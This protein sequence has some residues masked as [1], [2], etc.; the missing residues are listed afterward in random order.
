MKKLLQTLKQKWS[1]YLLEMI[2]ITM[3][4]LG[5]FMLNSWNDQRQTKVLEKEIY[6]N[7]FSS[8]KTDSIQLVRT[9]NYLSTSLE[10]QEIVMNGSYP[11][12]IECCNPTDLLQ[13]IG[14]GV[15]S[16]FPKLGVYKQITNNGQLQLLKTTE[17]KLA[18]V[19][20]YDFKYKRY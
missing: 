14:M 13:N 1:E 17:I 16:F 2:V 9:I 19:E 11:E 4:I 6:Q 7:L 8:L 15:T 20:L 10:S 18:L 12:I 3:G 5:A